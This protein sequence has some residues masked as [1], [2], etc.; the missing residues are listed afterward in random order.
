LF[1]AAITSAVSLLEII[2][3]FFEDELGFNRVKASIFSGV[4]IFG[5]GIFASLSFGPMENSRLLGKNPFEWMDFLS[6]KVL[7]PLGGIAIALFA[8]WKAWPVIR[9]ELGHSSSS[10]SFMF[11]LR[12]M[13][14]VGA[15]L[16]IGWV[17]IQGLR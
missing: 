1:F 13:C 9:E 11:M 2:T 5:L 17:L 4:L 6:S 7:L 14:C 8:G 12:F 3:I 16:G 15:P 10:A